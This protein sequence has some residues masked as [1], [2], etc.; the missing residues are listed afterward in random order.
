MWKAY[1]HWKGE[2]EVF[3]PVTMTALTVASAALAAG[4]TI[5][6]GQAAKKSADFTAA[7]EDQA[8]QESRAASQRDALEKGRQTGLVLSKLQARAAASGGGAADPGV[9]TIA[10]NIAGRGEY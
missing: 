8:A 2:V 4:G 3:D 7:Q 5:M 6:G 1:R 9:L 10:G